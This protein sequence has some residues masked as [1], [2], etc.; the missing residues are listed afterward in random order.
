M[1]CFLEREGKGEGRGGGRKSEERGKRG[2]ERRER[3]GRRREREGG[4]GR[5]R[6]R[7]ER[8]ER[9]RERGE[10]RGRGRRRGERERRGRGLVLVT[11]SPRSWQGRPGSAHPTKASLGVGSGAGEGWGFLELWIQGSGAGE[12]LLGPPHL[13]PRPVWASPSGRGEG[14]AAAT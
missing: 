5:E 9:G 7:E 11:D 12:P 1:Y 14:R 8:E 13:G 3:G 4:E 2:E 6:E 10:R